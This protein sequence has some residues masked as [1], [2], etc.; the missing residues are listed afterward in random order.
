MPNFGR[1]RNVEMVFWV[2][3][4][5]WCWFEWNTTVLLQRA[6]NRGKPLIL[7]T[8]VEI[9]NEG[10][11]TFT[12]FDCV[13]VS[14]F[15]RIL[16]SAFMGR[17]RSE[18]HRTCRCLREKVSRFDL[19]LSVIPGSR[20]TKKYVCGL[21]TKNWNTLGHGEYNGDIRQNFCGCTDLLQGWASFLRCQTVTDQLETWASAHRCYPGSDW[22]HWSLEWNPYS[23][24]I[25]VVT[26]LA[27]IEVQQ[28]NLTTKE[29]PVVCTDICRGVQITQAAGV[30]GIRS[31][32]EDQYIRGWESEMRTRRGDVCIYS[33]VWEVAHGTTYMGGW[34]LNWCTE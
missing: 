24:K 34:K 8:A 11:N 21:E 17:W 12:P 1:C 31:A 6:V 32:R 29:I 7:V 19:E 25:L 33:G 9:V 23:R 10:C 13:S 30:P 18:T 27:L 20:T 15:K 16:C 22:L 14:L 4:H 2:T 28:K 26:Q 3:H 5:I